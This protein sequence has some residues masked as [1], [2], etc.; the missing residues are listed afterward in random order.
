MREKLKLI[1]YRFNRLKYRPACNM[2]ITF[3]IYV[4]TRG[5]IMYCIQYTHCICTY[6]NPG[7]VREPYSIY[8]YIL[9]GL[10]T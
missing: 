5:I 8:K 3:E 1:S 9:K 4:R 7:L 10:F 2:M 6:F